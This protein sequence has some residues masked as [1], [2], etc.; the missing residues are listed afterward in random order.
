MLRFIARCC[1]GMLIWPILTSVSRDGCVAVSRFLLPCVT[2]TVCCWTVSH[3]AVRLTPP[4]SRRTACC[5]WQQSTWCWLQHINIMTDWMHWI[6]KRTGNF[7]RSRSLGDKCKERAKLPPT[8]PANR[9]HVAV[10]SIKQ[11]FCSVFTWSLTSLLADF[12]NAAYCCSRHGLLAARLNLVFF[13]I[14]F[15]YLTYFEC[16]C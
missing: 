7:E 3:T 13:K 10:S 5:E 9:F 14:T 11:L 1:D 15:K 2:F 16:L 8:L 6:N 4:F 12:S